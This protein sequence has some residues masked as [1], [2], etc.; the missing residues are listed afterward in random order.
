MKIDKR[1][2]SI[3]DNRRREKPRSNSLLMYDGNQRYTFLNVTIWECLRF[4]LQ[5]KLGGEDIK[6]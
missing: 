6:Y 1:K 5:N 3:L 4:W 2:N